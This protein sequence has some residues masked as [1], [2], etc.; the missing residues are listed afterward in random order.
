[1]SKE[2]VRKGNFRIHH[3]TGYPSRVYNACRGVRRETIRH[4][5][6]EGMKILTALRCRKQG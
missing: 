5:R 6:D 2:I 1:M 3:N 4:Q